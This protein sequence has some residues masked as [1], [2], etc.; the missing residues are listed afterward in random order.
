MTTRR[1]KIDPFTKPKCG[2]NKLAYNTSI[3]RPPHPVDRDDWKVSFGIVDNSSWNSDGHDISDLRSVLEPF[4]EKLAANFIVAVSSIPQVRLARYFIDFRAERPVAGISRQRI[5]G[6]AHE[7]L[8][9]ESGYQKSLESCATTLSDMMKTVDGRGNVRVH[10]YYRS[11]SER[12]LSIIKSNVRA[13]GDLLIWQWEVHLEVLYKNLPPRD[14]WVTAAV[15]IE[16]QTSLTA[17]GDTLSSISTSL[18]ETAEAT[19]ATENGDLAY[20]TEGSNTIA[21]DDDMQAH[22]PPGGQSSSEV[23]EYPTTDTKLPEGR[24]LKMGVLDRPRR[25]TC[26]NVRYHND[27][28]SSDSDGSAD[29]SDEF[30][31]HSRRLTRITNRGRNHRDSK[32][33]ERMGTPKAR[34]RFPRD[35]RCSAYHGEDGHDH[36]SGDDSGLSYRPVRVSNSIEGTSVD[37]TAG[38]DR[39]PKPRPSPVSR[40]KAPT[41][42]R[43]RSEATNEASPSERRNCTGPVDDKRDH[44]NQATLLSS[45]STSDNPYQAPD[46]SP[47]D[48]PPAPNVGR[49]ANIVLERPSHYSTRHDRDTRMSSPTKQQSALE[50]RGAMFA[51]MD[52]SQTF[53]K[54]DGSEVG[55]G[56]QTDDDATSF[57]SHASSEPYLDD[58]YYY[59]TNMVLRAKVDCMTSNGMGKRHRLDGRLESPN[60]GRRKRVIR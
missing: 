29:G 49:S 44:Q 43:E 39:V 15:A 33:K 40:I 30:A 27:T 8:N 41:V 21:E 48:S 51:C 5:R 38:H 59:H 32:G 60:A 53:M 9:G 13:Y 2:V 23:A 31:G 28:A 36:L 25:S 37:S 24:G 4:E 14:V 11:L 16:E 57:S 47:S 6:T 54:E 22:F 1:F 45:F 19:I 12:R 56:E 34:T 52:P 20:E 46:L 18:Q 35:T 26:K 50:S 55:C 42:P 58:P 7:R 3:R 10:P 17:H